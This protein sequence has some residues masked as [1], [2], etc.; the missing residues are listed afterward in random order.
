[1]NRED[2]LVN[3]RLNELQPCSWSSFVY[4]SDK[5]DQQSTQSNQADHLLEQANASPTAKVFP[6]ST[7]QVGDLVRIVS[8]NCGESS[9]RLMGMGFIPDVILEII[10]CT[11][12][13]S[14]IV[15]FGNQ[16]LGLGAEMTKRIQVMDA[17]AHLG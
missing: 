4:I 8:L 5:V 2:G 14:M 9:N 17:E 7:M 3:H 16:R 13:G 15:A 10:S 1:M 6:L 12:T 11:S